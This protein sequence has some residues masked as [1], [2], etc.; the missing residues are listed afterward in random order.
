MSEPRLPDYEKG[1]CVDGSLYGHEWQP[2][3]FVFESQLLDNDGR[4]LIRQPAIDNGRVYCVCM[5]CHQHTYLV[6]QWAGFFIPS[7]WVEQA[8]ADD[9]REWAAA[10]PGDA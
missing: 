6:T 2:L 8:E 9:E 7:P 1:H 4:V 5:K 3:S 10:H